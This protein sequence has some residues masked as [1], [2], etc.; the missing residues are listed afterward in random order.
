M[1]KETGGPA[2]KLVET[3][4]KLSDAMLLERAK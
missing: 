3:A 2:D 4:F 1:S